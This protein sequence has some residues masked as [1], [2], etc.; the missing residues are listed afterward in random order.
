MAL[1]AFDCWYHDR[2]LCCGPPARFAVTTMETQRTPEF[3]SEGYFDKLKRLNESR[4]S[5]HDT[6][7][8]HSLDASAQ[9]SSTFI[10]PIK[11]RSRSP[12]HAAH[13]LH[14]TEKRRNN[15]SFRSILPSRSSIDHDVRRFSSESVA[16][17]KRYVDS[18]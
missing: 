14:K 11:A 9:S 4:D 12:E 6:V 2:Y 15:F 3:A 17:P 13:E 10:L 18:Q 8:R 7:P 16:K 1:P 5:A